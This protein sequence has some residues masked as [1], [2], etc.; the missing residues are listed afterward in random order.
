MFVLSWRCRGVFDDGLLDVQQCVPR[1]LAWRRGPRGALRS[2]HL[3][4]MPALPAGHACRHRSFSWAVL[5]IAVSF[6][7]FAIHGIAVVL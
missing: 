5:A 2:R 1:S 7:G 6:G 4:S 3:L